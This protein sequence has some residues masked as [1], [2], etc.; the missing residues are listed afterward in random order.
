MNARS[1][2]QRWLPSRSHDDFLAVES[3]SPATLTLR[4][5]RLVT[6]FDSLSRT[7]TQQGKLVA[8]FGAIRHVQIQQEG[9]PADGPQWWVSLQLA[10]TNLVR[11]GRC[12]EPSS[13]AELAA[14][15][16]SVTGVDV[17]P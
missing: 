12:P 17:L 3:E 14:R 4:Q 5:G 9:A 8:R 11:V 16:G 2:M 13:A 10:G 1:L 6:A 15:I 7:V